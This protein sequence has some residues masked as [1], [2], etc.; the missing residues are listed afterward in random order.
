MRTSAVG[1]RCWLRAQLPRFEHDMRSQLEP[2]VL[3]IDKVLQ[4]AARHS[5]GSRAI[6]LISGF[7]YI[8]FALHLGPSGTRLVILGL[9]QKN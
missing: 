9:L 5:W 1:K 2:P 6:F 8:L 3:E 7:E 4:P